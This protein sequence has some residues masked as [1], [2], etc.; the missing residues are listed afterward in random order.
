MTAFSNQFPLSFSAAPGKRSGL[1]SINLSTE[2]AG[3]NFP[4][5][6]AEWVVGD[7]LTREP[8]DSL[9]GS[10]FRNGRSWGI[11]PT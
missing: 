1:E 9:P 4:T 2:V 7:F 10:A 6:N 11:R 5:H 3:L 8:K